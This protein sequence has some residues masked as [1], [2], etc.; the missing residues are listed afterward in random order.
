[1]RSSRRWLTCALLVA[2]VAA[3][4][5]GPARIQRPTLGQPLADVS[6]E[7]TRGNAVAIADLAG[8]PAL[9][10]LWATWC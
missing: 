6:L 4:D 10:N 9:V 3:C 7:D 2:G 1:M 8:Q 5:G